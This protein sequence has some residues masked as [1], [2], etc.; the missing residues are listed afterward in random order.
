MQ[1]RILK[2]PSGLDLAGE[3]PL[4]LAVE[5]FW[6]DRV[7]PSGPVV[8]YFCLPGGSINRHYYNLQ[9][10][11]DDS[12]SFAA[13]MAN[14]GAITFAVDHLGVG[15]SDK[16]HDGFLLTPDRLAQANANVARKVLGGMREGS[17]VEGLP[18]LKHLVSIGVGHS[19]GGMLTVL[20][21]ALARQHD[22]LLL[23]GFANAGMMSHVPEQAHHLAGNPEAVKAEIEAVARAVYPEPYQRIAPSPEAS[24]IFQGATADRAGVDAIKP[25]RDNL[26]VVG[27]LQ[28]MI[29]GSIKPAL[30]TVDAPV[31]LGLGDRDIAGPPHAIPAIFPNSRDITLTVLP[32]TGHCQFIF[33]SRAELFRR[34]GEWT[35]FV[36]RHTGNA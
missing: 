33:P 22:G 27:G 10:P 14:Q 20:Q 6:P 13:M 34:I 11:G 18:A 30:D 25:T 19:M 28:S 15:D 36:I 4:D 17:L 2:I 31:F 12:F 32:E 5:L 24:Q 21:Q 35:S 16:P 29:P 3:G 1:H 8:S 23:M 26:L 9:A 7:D